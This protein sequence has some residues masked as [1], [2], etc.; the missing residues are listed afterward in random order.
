[1]NTG[2]RQLLAAVLLPLALSVCSVAF[3]GS[4]NSAVGEDKERIAGYTVGGTVTGLVIGERVHPTCPG[5]TGDKDALVTSYDYDSGTVINCTAAD[6]ITLGPDVFVLADTTLSLKSRSI[7]L[8]GKMAVEAGSQLHVL[9]IVPLRLNDTGIVDCSDDMGELTCPVATYP[10][11]DAEYGRDVTHNDNSD[12]HAG[13]SF[14]KLD[15]NGEPLLAS[16]TS[17]SCVRDNVTRLIWEVKTDDS[18]LQNKDYTYTWYNPDSAIN[19]G[20]AGV[21]DGGICT[22]GDCDTQGYVQAVNAQGLCGAADWRMPNLK[23][24]Q[25]IGAKDRVNPSIDI[26][27]FPNTRSST[28]WSSSPNADNSSNAWVLAFNFGIGLRNDKDH[29]NYVRLVRGGQ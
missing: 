19:G 27:Y 8:K 28:Y 13:F 24:L 4:A 21:Q 20:D 9:G 2:V 15:A 11:Q 16:A 6:S 18:G 22:V 7:Y 17:W 25:N 14:T 29:G 12:G 10:G 23:E 3:A 5:A 1:M 26:D